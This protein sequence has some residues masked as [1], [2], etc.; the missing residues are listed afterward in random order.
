[1]AINNYNNYMNSNL[2]IMNNQINNQM[3]MNQNNPIINYQNIKIYNNNSKQNIY[4]NNIQIYP[5]YNQIITPNFNQMK[6]NNFLNIHNNNQMNKN[7]FQSIINPINTINS[8]FNNNQNN[9]IKNERKSNIINEVD[10]GQMMIP[11]DTIIKVRKSIC[12]I[13]YEIN[14]IPYKGTGFFIILNNYFK[15][16]ITNY[17]VISKDLINIIIN[18]EIYNNKKIKIILNNN[19]Y[20]KFDEN[21]DISII[22]IKESDD[23]I[24]DIE[25]LYYDLNYKIGYE[26]YLNYDIF[27]LQYPKGKESYSSGKIIEIIKNNNKY[28]FMHNIKTD[29]GSSGCPIIIPYTLKV[30]GIHKGGDESLKINYGSFIGEILNEI[31]I[32]LNTIN[33]DN[34]SINKIK[35]NSLNLKNK[36]KNN[37]V[38]G[39]I[40]ISEKDIK[41][42]I[43]II[44]SF[45][46]YMREINSDI[47]EEY[48]NEKEIK[49]CKIEI[50]NKKIPFC[51]FYKFEEVGQYYIKY[52]FEDYLTKTN[53]MFCGCSSLNKLNLSN[54]NTQNVTNMACMFSDCCSL[55]NLNLSNFNTQNVTNMRCLFNNCYSL[56]N[57][58]VSNFNTQKVIYMDYMFSGCS[59][60]KNLNLSNFN[61]QNV[62]DMSQ[63]FSI[64]TFLTDLDLSNFNTKYVTN[65]SNMLDGCSSLTYLDLSNFNT[66][67]VTSM[68][69]MFSRC[70]SLTNL[71]LSNFNTQNVIIGMDSMFFFCKALEMKSINTKD[72]RILKLMKSNLF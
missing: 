33:K 32:E 47:K 16:I 37:Y 48:K 39:E 6:R 71:N 3:I 70:G 42:K 43:R 15:C 12:K 54:F 30:I 49:E 5:N 69:Y 19:R 11:I 63:M 18:I 62:T 14:N 8:N 53:Y 9:K 4:K 67:N 64:C 72:S 23:I 57:L 1:M 2:K 7:N 56:K 61:T 24:I 35:E 25:F 17:H 20:Y 40:N 58:N 13:F 27:T 68:E 31:E 51:Y 55:T 10:T 46:E 44:N 41:K 29:Y 36:L 38:I 59:S 50:N 22:E 66:Q 21:I 34:Y 26:Q 28:E 65:M 60:L 52:S 45:E